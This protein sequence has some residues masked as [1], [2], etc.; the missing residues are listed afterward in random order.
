MN[1]KI[2]R[3]GI[4]VAVLCML[5]VF[6]FAV[7]AGNIDPDGDG[8]KYA[9]GENI[10]WTNFAPSQGD[11]VTVT[12]NAV[13]G[14][15]W[16]ENIG[17][18]NLS[19]AQYGGITHDGAG[20]LSGYAWGENVGW[21]SF[22][23]QNTQS[24]E[25]VDGAVDYGVTIDPATGAFSGKAWG[26]NVGWISF[27]SQLQTAFMIITSWKGLFTISGNVVID[28]AGH[29][30]L[31]VK[32]ATVSLE[33]T[34]YTATTDSNGDFTIAN[35]PPGTYTLMV[36]AQDLVPISQEI[37]L[38]DVQPFDLRMRILV[39][40][41]LDQAVADAIQHWDAKGDDK[42]GLEEAIHALQVVAGLR[43][44]GWKCQD[45]DEENGIYRICN[46]FPINPGNTWKFTTG[47]R[48]I[49]NEERECNGYSGLRFGTSSYEYSLFLQNAEDGLIANG[50][51]YEMPEGEFQ[52]LGLILKFANPEMQIGE[53]VTTSFSDTTSVTSTLLGPESV[54]VPAGTFTA[55]K[56]VIDMIDTNP[57]TNEQ[58]YCNSYKT[59]LW[60]AK[61]I[62]PVKIHRT[63]PDPPGNDICWGCMFVC[64]PDN[65]FSK[66]NSPAELVSA[67]VDGTTY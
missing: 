67:V 66:V 29:T 35:V 26:E 5:P 63:D 28:I 59:T 8:H 42:I 33:G 45:D 62:G 3:P 60:L 64:R 9:F 65:D 27:D 36:T 40:G 34:S 38:P 52:D 22:S 25:A 15:A 30:D 41:D 56:L 48:I 47:D 21:I 50:C 57:N 37:T 61:G 19:P 17:W 7:Y 46:Y 55:L 49:L 31:S 18:I 58:Q 44:G 4:I 54:T 24:C 23:C 2:I 20:N 53:S 6:C 43:P 10:G 12:D 14:Y 32:K 51:F 16:A 39:Q 1:S 11:G 13:T